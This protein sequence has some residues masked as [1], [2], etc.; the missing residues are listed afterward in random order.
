ML[1]DREDTNTR[2]VELIHRQTCQLSELDCLV[3]TTITNNLALYFCMDSLPAYRHHV[4]L[5]NTY[6]MQPVISMMVEN[7]KCMPLPRNLAYL[8]YDTSTSTI[9]LRNFSLLLHPFLVT[10]GESHL[11]IR[12]R[13]PALEKITL[14]SKSINVRPYHNEL[15]S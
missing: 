7:D 6:I 11:H 14:L 10:A 15:A 8:I 5:D 2:T 3:I 12:H 4:H 13:L 1:I 9:R